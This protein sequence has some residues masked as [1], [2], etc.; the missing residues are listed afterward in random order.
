MARIR[1]IKPEFWQNEELSAI[2][3]EA[4]LLAIALLN[5]ADDYGYFRA[6]P[7]LIKAACFPIRELS[8]NVPRMLSELSRVGYI[9]LGETPDGKTYGLIVNFSKHQRVDK[10]NQSQISAL[11]ITW[12]VLDDDSTNVPRIVGDVSGTEKEK[13]GNSKGIGKG[14]STA[15]SDEPAP[16]G[17][18]IA[19]LAKHSEFPQ[20]FQEAMRHYPKRAGDNPTRR[21]FQAWNAR[22][23][24]GETPETIVAGVMRYAAFCDATGKTNTELVKQ[25]ATFF[26]PDKAYLQ[27]WDTPQTVKQNQSRS[28][29]SAFIDEEFLHATH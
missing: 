15:V 26:G 10:P 19:R 3:A 28:A 4:A 7:Q 29:I 8:S 5:Y 11:S 14:S 20:P 6:H 17:Q 13:E 24:S 21:A 1:T 27:P 2:S 12:K 16:Q 9:K 23:K 25:A 18:Q 22:V